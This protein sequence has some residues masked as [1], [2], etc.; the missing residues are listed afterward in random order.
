MMKRYSN[1]SL[2]AALL[3]GM[4]TLV[5]PASAQLELPGGGTF[6]LFGPPGL[7]PESKVQLK[8]KGGPFNAIYGNFALAGGGELDWHV[9]P[10][11]AIITVTKGMFNEH[12]SNGCVSLYEAGD[13]FFES[14]GQVHK[15]VNPSA[16]ESAEALIAFLVPVGS[17]LV[18]F[19][20]PPAETTC[21]PGEDSHGGQKPPSAELAEIKAALDA[22]TGAI[23]SI[24]S[25]L[26]RIARALSLN[27]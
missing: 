6:D 3:G 16:T 15:I 2:L 10:G 27:P 25:L 8:A 11:V 26:S 23:E 21:D 20:P 4:L 18:T 9:N 17:D 24:Q 1:L 14:E 12:H 22:N 13:V 7:S 19:V 5:Q